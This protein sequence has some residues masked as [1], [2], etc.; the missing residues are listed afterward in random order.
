MHL[1]VDNM[2]ELPTVKTGRTKHSTI[3]QKLLLFFIDRRILE[4]DLSVMEN[5]WV[6]LKTLKKCKR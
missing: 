2:L 6:Q 3:F 5:E 1:N 4:A